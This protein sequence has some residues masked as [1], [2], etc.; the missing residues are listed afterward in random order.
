MSD[1]QLATVLA[2]ARLAWP[3]NRVELFRDRISAFGDVAI[4]PLVG[5]HRTEPA[6]RF[7]VVAVLADIARR[8]SA[9]ARTVLRSLAEHADD[10]H[11]KNYIQHS[12]TLANSIDR[13]PLAGPMAERSRS[14]KRTSTSLQPQWQ[15]SSESW[16]RPANLPPAEQPP[17]PV[18]RINQ[19]RGRRG[20]PELDAAEVAHV[21]ANLRLRE[22]DQARYRN[23]C[24]VC[25]AV[26][27]ESTNPH[28][29]ACGWLVCWCGA[30]RE[31]KQPWPRPHGRVG[32][33]RNE[34][35]LFAE[36]LCYPDRDFL[37]RA[38]L[39]AVLPALDAPDIRHLLARN[40]VG[41]VF[42]WSPARS[43]ASII[44]NGILSRSELARR[45]IRNWVP[46]GYGSPE[47]ERALAG[48]VGVAFRVKPLM[49]REW[50]TTPVVFEL[51]P[52]ILAGDGTLFVPGNSA[53]SRFA[54]TELSSLRGAAALENLFVRDRVLA[55]G[56]AEA[57]IKVR[58]PCVAIRAIH[59]ATPDLARR[60]E[61]RLPDWV[62]ETHVAP[63]VVVSTTMFSAFDPSGVAHPA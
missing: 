52:E 48:R 38:I 23:V 2:A 36:E 37:G 8:G 45:G 28:C 44:Q 53:A 5:M 57:W 1:D 29:A 26:V 4:A 16:F 55:D 20:E 22:L 19:V 58:V 9:Q 63:T 51:N 27:D 54:T 15:P 49:M 50:S 32:P 3:T 46:H 47:K 61:A 59:V 24:W 62:G 30:C 11:L 6:L 7:F 12:L 13:G 33:C 40:G 39:T 56:Q 42:H 25:R 21:V 43:V 41:S 17:N 31:P 34:A 18:E 14:G 60:L 35:Y 10:P